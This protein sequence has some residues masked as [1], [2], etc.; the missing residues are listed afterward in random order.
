[1]IKLY[2]KPIRVNKSSQGEGKSGEGS[3]DVGANLFLGTL[4]EEVDE[5]VRLWEKKGRESVS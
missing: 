3:V 4:S 2:G 5:K 1:M